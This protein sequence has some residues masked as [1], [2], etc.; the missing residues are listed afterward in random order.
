MSSAPMDQLMEDYGNNL[1]ALVDSVKHLTFETPDGKYY[2]VDRF[3]QNQVTKK[4]VPV[5]CESFKDRDSG[6]MISVVDYW[7]NQ[8]K[9]DGRS[10][11]NTRLPAVQA[12]IGRQHISFPAEI[13]KLIPGQKPKTE[14]EAHK[15]ALIRASAK[16]APER[17][18]TIQS[19]V[20]DKELYGD[21]NLDKEFGFKVDSTPMRAEA[22]VLDTPTILDGDN[23][24][25]KVMS[26]IY[27]NC[28]ITFI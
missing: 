12:K 9:R 2:K 24:E 6:R 15:A 21:P 23:R 26:K 19:M 27:G 25:I 11:R 28:I 5:A 8:L 7:N 18:Q 16:P 3:R 22:T 17:L 14:R 13:C 20:A 1:N 4:W 10:L